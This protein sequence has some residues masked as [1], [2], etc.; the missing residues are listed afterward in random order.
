MIYIVYEKAIFEPTFGDIYAEL[1][2]RLSHKTKQ[3]PF[4]KIIESDEEPPTEDGVV[5]EGS[6]SSSNN[7]VYRW[8]NDVSTND[9]EVVGPFGTED[10]CIRAALDSN[11]CPDPILRGDM[12]L[13]LHSLKIKQGVFI[14]ILHAKD[15]P[16]SLYTVFFSM[17][18]IDE[19]GQQ[20]SKIFLSHRECEKSGNKENSFKGILL[21]KCE[22]EFVKQNRYD[23]W[24]EEKKVF[25]EEK[26]Q[27]TLTERELLEKEEDLEFRRMK[28]K[29]QV[30]GN[31][32]FIGELFKK[33][34]LKPKIMRFCIQAILRIDE[35]DDGNLI[36]KNED[37]DEE[38]HEALCKLFH[39]IGNTVDQGKTRPYIDIYFKKI[40]ELS[41]DKKNLSSRSRFM[42]KDLIDLRRN[43]WVAR[44]EEETA[45]TLDEIK[46]DFERDE[47]L[48]QQQ[49]QQMHN[50][51]R[52]NGGRGNRSTGRGGGRGGRGDYRDDRRDQYSSNRQ[53]SQR[54]EIRPD[55]DGFTQVR[56][57]GSA[58]ME[59]SFNASTPKILARKSNSDT[60]PKSTQPPKAPEPTPL[61]KEQL[62]K[63]VKG[64]KTEYVESKDVKELLLSMDELRTTPD[65]GKTL[66]QVN[67]DICVDCRDAERDAIF[68]MFITLY[69]KG[70]LT[71]SDIQPPLAEMIEFLGS[72][73]A[74]SP[75]IIKHLSGLVAEFIN[76]KALDLAWV[77]E[78][79]MKL[80]EFDSHVIPD[81][82]ENLIQALIN[83]IGLNDAK[84]LVSQN[85]SALSGLTDPQTWS[86]I[87]GN[88]NI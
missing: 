13:S 36:Y 52:G 44:R 19:V 6:G 58:P 59:R 18:N 85:E 33:E 8:S 49:S 76:L 83:K 4:V 10:E 87:R 26:R 78:Q 1:C 17:D 35:S 20:I 66:V 69:E 9:N 64:M 82:I 68:E 43:R 14:K 70:K 32:R 31:I 80:Q 46:R 25:D 48:A 40:E 24:K 47:R 84:S 28:I 71:P 34:M 60:R 41:S 62:E 38:D 5:G 16:N 22:D 29:K 11:I 75:N 12:E 27:G 73:V 61:T 50:N 57:G 88:T 63:R 39:T 42:Y 65:A 79:T 72:F 7:T 37:M 21:N 51:Y 54:Q 56:R 67:L 15:D 74:D 77:C 23:T 3:N 81:V 86:K 53:R 45:K 30:L 2:L 55:K